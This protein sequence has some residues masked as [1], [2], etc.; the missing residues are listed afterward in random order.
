MA[1]ELEL[2][3]AGGFVE[4]FLAFLRSSDEN[5]V[6][7]A[8]PDDGVGA[9]AEAGLREHHLD[10]GEADLVFVDEVFR[11]A[12]AI[13][14]SGDGDFGVAEAE[15][16]VFVVEEKRHFGKTAARA[17]FGAGKDDVFGLLAAEELD[18]LL[19]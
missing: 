17:L 15:F 5:P 9:G 10:V 6:S 3:D 16:V 2:A 8:L 7:H 18:A 1:L 4:E 13:E 14:T 19:T 12:I 11:F